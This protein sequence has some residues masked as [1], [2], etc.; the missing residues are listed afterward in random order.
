M[1]VLRNV[2]VWDLVARNSEIAHYSPLVIGNEDLRA[3]SKL[4]KTIKLL[5]SG[6]YTLMII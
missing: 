1:T 4:R 2:V 3:N 5:V 6:D